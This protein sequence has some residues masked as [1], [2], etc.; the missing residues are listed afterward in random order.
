[1][2][3]KQT[4]PLSNCRK[5]APHNNLTFNKLMQWLIYGQ[6]KGTSSGQND[7]Y[8]FYCYVI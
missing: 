7:L 8:T 2:H 1:M 6:K 4:P 3:D 5:E